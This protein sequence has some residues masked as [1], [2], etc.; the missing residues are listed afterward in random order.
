MT[1]QFNPDALDPDEHRE[2]LNDI[3][4]D[5][6]VR[7]MKIRVQRQARSNRKQLENLEAMALLAYAEFE[8]DNYWVEEIIDTARSFTVQYETLVQTIGKD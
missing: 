8:I 5:D 4:N 7:R 1:I 6:L 3:R 2:L